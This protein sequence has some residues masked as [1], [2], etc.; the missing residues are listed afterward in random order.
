[1]K[2]MSCEVAMTWRWWR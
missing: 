1:M 2:I